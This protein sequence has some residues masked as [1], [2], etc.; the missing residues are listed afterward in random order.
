MVASGKAERLPLSGHQTSAIRLQPSAIVKRAL[1][2]VERRRRLG[3]TI[4][5]AR[6]F[7][8]RLA[9]PLISTGDMTIFWH[10]NNDNNNTR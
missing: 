3:I 1:N 7:C 6:G 10:R 8:S 2:F 9:L 5:Q 4:E